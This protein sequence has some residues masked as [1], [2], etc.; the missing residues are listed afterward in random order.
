MTCCGLHNVLLKLEG[1]YKNWSTTNSENDIDHVSNNDSP[2]S[3]NRLNCTIEGN[4]VDNCEVVNPS[5]FE[6]YVEDG[7]QIVSKMPLKLF[8]QCLVNHFHIRFKMK[9]VFW[10]LHKKNIQPSDIEH[11]FE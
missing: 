1:Y 7:Y 4:D 8:R 9:S 11:N 3:I 6:E 2:F 10:P 5:I